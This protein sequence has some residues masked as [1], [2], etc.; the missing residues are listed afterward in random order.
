MSTADGSG[1]G[2]IVTIDAGSNAFAWRLSGV[3]FGSALVGLVYLLVATM[4]SRRRIAV[5]AAAFVAL[6][7]MSYVM[8]RISMNDIFVATFIVAAYLVFWQV[9]SGRWARSAWWALPLVGV[10][11]GLA[12][13]SKW[14][15]FYALGGLLVLV[16]ARSA[17]GRL[18]LVALAAFVLVLGA[19]G[20]PWPFLVV[21]LALLALALAITWVRPIRLDVGESIG[22]LAATAM[23]VTGVGL[24][25]VLAYPSVEGR[26]P[27]KRRRVRVRPARSGC[28]G[29]VAGLDHDRRGRRAHRLAGVSVAARPAF[30]RALVPARRDGRIRLVVGRR[31]PGDRA[32]G[33]V[34]ADLHPV[35]A[36][37]P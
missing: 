37:R 8:S 15:G 10:L 22:A 1:G 5:L 13:A 25:F 30:G 27:G 4:F 29:R 34:R 20:G 7:P 36:A 32:A 6:D 3:I 33:R 12:A 9:W 35:P 31:V 19:I 17:L 26:E 24:A 18:L 2:S 11:I 16:L 23:V 14:V 28:R 21:M